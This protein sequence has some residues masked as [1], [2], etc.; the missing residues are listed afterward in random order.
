MINNDLQAIILAAGKSKRFNGKTSK[1]AEKICGQEMILH[2]TSALQTLNIDTTVVV[3]HQKELIE[4]LIRTHHQDNIKFAIQEKQEGTGHAV[5]CSRKTWHK[6][7]ILVMNGDMPL[8]DAELIQMLYQQH[9]ASK[10]IMSL[11]IAYDIDPTGAYGRIIQKD[12]SLAIIEAKEFTHKIAD[13]P[14]INAGIYLFDRAFLEATIDTINR[15][16]QSNEFYITDLVKIASDQHKKINPVTVE[17]SKVRGINTYGEFVTAEQI[18]RT[19]IISGW[20]N[21]GI[22]FTMPQT[23]NI[24]IGV[25]IGT[26]STIESGVQLLGTT[27]IG[28]QC[29]IGSFSYIKNTHIEDQVTIHPYCFIKDS[30]I[31]AKSSV[32]PFAYI[33]N[34]FTVP[35][36]SQSCTCNQQQKSV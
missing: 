3:G 27:R 11:A 15:N 19:N 33:A 28:S 17:L 7:L 4:E 29:H 10:A 25:V 20:I 12:G 2:I 22:K 24:D 8:V 14:F 18:L 26:G 1:L 30:T 21:K 13:Y 31:A 9:V 34:N 35:V 23:V 16:Q 6:E 5:A 32:G 36:P